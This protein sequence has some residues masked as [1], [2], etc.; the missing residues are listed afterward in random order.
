[1][2]LTGSVDEESAN[3]TVYAAVF[4]NVEYSEADV[5]NFF[6]SEEFVS[7]PS[8]KLKQQTK[9]IDFVF[10]N[11]HTN[12]HF[13]DELGS[14]LSNVTD[15]Y[16]VIVFVKDNDHVTY[17]KF[18]QSNDQSVVYLEDNEAPLINNKTI[19]SRDYYANVSFETTDNENTVDVRAVVFANAT[20]VSD[21]DARD[22]L[23]HANIDTIG[24]AQDNVSNVSTS[25]T[26]SL[27]K[28][29]D[30]SYISTE[31]TVATTTDNKVKLNEHIQPD[32]Y[33]FRNRVYTFQVNSALPLYLSSSLDNTDSALGGDPSIAYITTD[34]QEFNTLTEGL[35]NIAYVRFKVSSAFTANTYYYG[36]WSTPNAGGM[37][38]VVDANDAST[39]P[40]VLTTDNTH[41][42]RM[43][44][45]ARDN[46]R[47]EN[48]HII[49]TTY[50][51]GAPPV[52]VSLNAEFVVV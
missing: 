36:L 5:Q 32:I 34:N 25:F 4:G 33:L 51:V 30:M 37:I 10:E 23:R 15:V 18:Y 28:A 1:V 13:H 12:I 8:T 20:T 43:F 3:I 49:G 35:S 50:R 27:S 7:S 2:R 21:N 52:I 48:N 29:I 41:D 16:K 39:I 17:D 47:R 31:Y 9:D 44:V 45:Y 38:H 42:Y 40:T 6:T 24:F 19:V 22:F 46:S 14:I 26:Y 11:Y